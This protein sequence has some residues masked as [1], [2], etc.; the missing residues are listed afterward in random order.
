M[1]GKGH[2]RRAAWDG[3]EDVTV[4]VGGGVVLYGRL[5]A[6]NTAQEIPGS[7]IVFTHG[8]FGSLDGVDNENEVEALRRAGHHVLAI[9][10]RGHGETNCEHPEYTVSFGIRESSDFLAVA[11]W[12]KKE[13]GATRVGLVSF[14]L[15]GYEALLTAWLDGAETVRRFDGV[16]LMRELPART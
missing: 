15:T 1:D 8:L 6:P 14:S 13:K 12:L 7:Y 5:G 9:E 10:M 3:F 4:P 2:I 16:P 11:E